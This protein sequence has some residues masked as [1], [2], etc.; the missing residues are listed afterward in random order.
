MP[1]RYERHGSG[2]PV[3]VVAPGR[4]ATVPEMRAVASGITGTKVFLSAPGDLRAVAREVAATQALGASMGARAL[5]LALA[6]EPELFSRNIF[7]LPAPVAVPPLDR[8]TGQCLVIG[9]EGDDVHPATVA[10]ELA[11]ACR[12]VRLNPFPEPGGLLTH[13]RALRALLRDFVSAS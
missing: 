12:D 9:Q 5:V 7:Y 10:R 4:G 6:E 1:S 3:T 11:A 13:R 8:V 2:L